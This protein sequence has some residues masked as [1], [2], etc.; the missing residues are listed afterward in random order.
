MKI[1]FRLCLVILLFQN[2]TVSKISDYP[3]YKVSGDCDTIPPLNIGV[4][5]FAKS[6]LNKKVGRGEC[7]DLASEALQSVDAKWDGQYKF[8]T[9]VNPKTD[10]IYPGDLI[11][12]EDVKIYYM[13]GNMKY[14]EAMKHHTAIV[15]KVNS[16]GN[17]ELIHQNY[18]LKKRVLTSTLELKNIIKGKVIFFRPSK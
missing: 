10:C 8:G 13:K 1:L 4:V 14:Y 17:Y 9:K 16:K 6:K 3:I 12:F 7:W 5:D 2:F 11:Q 18:D 15:L